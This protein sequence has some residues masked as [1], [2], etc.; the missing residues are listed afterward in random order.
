[1]S[2]KLLKVNVISQE[3]S[4]YEAHAKIVSLRGSEGEM[5]ISFGHTQLLSTLPPGV[6]RIECENGKKDTLYIS[7]GVLEVQPHQVIVLTDVMERAKD[8]NEAATERAR[9]QA[10]KSLKKAHN[11]DKVE[12][13][14]A[15]QML[16]EAEMRLK[17]IKV[18]KGINSYYNDSDK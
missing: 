17:A 5:G 1:M 14:E 11:I 12:V 10:E 16:A 9:Q 15:R 8:L 3:G 18:L 7:G 6:V 4:V 2:D 13:K